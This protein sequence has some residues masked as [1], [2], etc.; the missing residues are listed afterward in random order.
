VAVNMLTKSIERSMPF[1]VLSAHLDDAVLSCGS[2]IIHA[3]GRTSV[4]VATLFTEAAPPPYTLSARRHLHQVAAPDAESLY[5]QRRVEDRAALEPMGVSCVHA[6]LTE[7]QY[8][9]RRRARSRRSL[10]GLLPEFNHIY[11]VYRWHVVSGRVAPD[12][13]GTLENACSFIRRVTCLG[14]AGQPL[15]LAPLG[16]GGN[17]DHVLVRMAA[18]H[19]GARIVYYSDFPYNQ[20]Q[21]P[22]DAFIRRNSLVEVQWL[23]TVA[24]LDLIRAYRTQVQALFRGDSI[25]LVPE[26]YYFPEDTSSPPEGRST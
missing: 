18:E 6:G 20:R 16:V 26:V 19:S 2:L 3:A 4:T 23:P 10:V 5:R 7:A 24:K 12:D 9:L 21:P 14:P 8:R 1:V 11:P 22:D 13:A 17:V 15:V 25:P